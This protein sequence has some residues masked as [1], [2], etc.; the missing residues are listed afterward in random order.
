M[1]TVK[2]GKASHLTARYLDR[3]MAIVT[4]YTD[5]NNMKMAPY[6]EDF[7]NGDDDDEDDDSDENASDQ[8]F[9]FQLQ[10]LAK[11]PCCTSNQHPCWKKKGNFSKFV[12][13][14]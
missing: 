14:C 12:L 11:S 7:D 8:Q 10:N 2:K 5:A 13:I 9:W 3:L 1:V 6:Y 4:K